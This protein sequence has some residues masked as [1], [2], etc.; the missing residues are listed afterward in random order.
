MTVRACDLSGRTCVVTGAGSGL[1][2]A[3]V[4]V[5]AREG[6]SV[7]AVDRDFSWQPDPEVSVEQVIADVTDTAAAASLAARLANVDVIACFA[8]IS[9]GGKLEDLTDDLWR[10]VFDV[11][12]LGT[13]RWITAFL[14]QLRASGRGSIITVASQLAIAGGRGNP[15]YLA[16]KGAI[17]SLTRCLAL[18][19]PPGLEPGTH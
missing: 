19:H 14:P 10:K 7:F 17:L 18:V 3:T 13:T 15:S 6:A 2:A 1:G 12:V 8:A 11:N 5:F 9:V 4:D 16:S